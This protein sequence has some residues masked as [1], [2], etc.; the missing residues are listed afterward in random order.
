VPKHVD[1]CQHD[2]DTEPREVHEELGT[3]KWTE[4]LLE[5]AKQQQ[6]ES[7]KEGNDGTDTGAVESGIFIVVNAGDVIN[8][9]AFVQVAR[10]VVKVGTVRKV[11]LIQTNRTY[12]TETRRKVEN[13]ATGK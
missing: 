2:L 7:T 11:G 9:D 5:K 1:E 12:H 13:V 3:R 10:G 6:H 4:A 8:G